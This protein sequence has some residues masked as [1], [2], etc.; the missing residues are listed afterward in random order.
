MLDDNYLNAIIVC[1]MREKKVSGLV[2]NPQ[3]LKYHN[4]RNTPGMIRAFMKFAGTKKNAQY[5]NFYFKKT[6]L[7]AFRQHL[8]TS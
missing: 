5:V 3:F 1:G 6:E 7:F 4:I 8:E 2:I